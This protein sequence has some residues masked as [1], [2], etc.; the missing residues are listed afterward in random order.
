M[1][2]LTDVEQSWVRVCVLPSWTGVWSGKSQVWPWLSPAP[3]CCSFCVLAFQ[4]PRCSSPGARDADPPPPHLPASVSLQQQ[5][6][7]NHTDASKHS[8]RSRMCLTLNVPH[9]I[10]V[11]LN[12][13]NIFMFGR[14]F[15]LPVKRHLCYKCSVVQVQDVV[16]FGFCVSCVLTLSSLENLIHSNPPGA[17]GSRNQ[18]D[19]GAVRNLQSETLMFN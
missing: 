3:S 6:D 7:K 9:L 13:L 8:G 15:Y 2:D 17:L 5:H 10:W 19:R 12:V 14:L 16:L 1:A 18:G 11:P 4:G